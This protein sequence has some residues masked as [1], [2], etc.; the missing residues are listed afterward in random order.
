MR[1]NQDR[2]STISSIPN[3]HTLMSSLRDIISVDILGDSGVVGR[4]VQGPAILPA[5]GLYQ[6]GQ[7]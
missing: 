6:G 2:P 3:H 4:F 1:L 7:V 5:G